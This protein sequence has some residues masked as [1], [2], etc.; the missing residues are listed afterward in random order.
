MTVV[1]PREDKK[2]VLTDAA[3]TYLAGEMVTAAHE[4]EHMDFVYEGLGAGSSGDFTISARVNRTNVTKS[5]T[6][7]LLVAIV[8][9]LLVRPEFLNYL[10]SYQH[11]H[12]EDQVSPCT[13]LLDPL[14]ICGKS[15]QLRLLFPTFVLEDVVSIQNRSK[16]MA[17]IIQALLSSAVR[18]WR[19]IMQTDS[20]EC[21][22]RTLN[23][24]SIE[25][26]AEERSPEDLRKLTTSD[27]LVKMAK[28]GM[29][30]LPNPHECHIELRR[31]V[32]PT[33][34]LCVLLGTIRT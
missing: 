10:L 26:G 6:R 16:A 30:I 2:E 17:H 33:E 20:D 3:H 22:V 32:Q 7:T 5:D 15:Q 13:L 19:W 8:Q 27:L 29:R 25:T 28:H 24:K 34:R 21:I 31:N 9:R 11:H 4:Y 1:G 14:I 12:R 18:E 23:M